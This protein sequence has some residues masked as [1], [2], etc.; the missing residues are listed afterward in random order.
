MLSS[1]EYVCFY[2]S[3]HTHV[4][5]SEKSELGIKALSVWVFAANNVYLYQ[6]DEKNGLEK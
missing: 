3:T 6:L 2:H 4:K 5:R 1:L